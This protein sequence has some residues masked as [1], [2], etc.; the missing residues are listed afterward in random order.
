VD[1]SQAPAV[2]SREQ[3][4]GVIDLYRLIKI[5]D[6]HNGE[7]TQGFLNFLVLWWL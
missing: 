4:A 2:C 5:V 1:F 3:G 6:E 7:A